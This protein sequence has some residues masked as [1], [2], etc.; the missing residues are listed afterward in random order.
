LA[1]GFSSVTCST[2]FDYVETFL[3]VKGHGLGES[4]RYQSFRAEPPDLKPVDRRARESTRGTYIRLGASARCTI[5]ARPLVWMAR[6]SRGF[7][8]LVRFPA[9]TRVE[10]LALASSRRSSASSAPSLRGT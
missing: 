3:D 4:S 2:F 7:S 9:Q 10:W 5:R 1:N 6:F 8:R